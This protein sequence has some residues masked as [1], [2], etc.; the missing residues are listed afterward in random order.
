MHH[1]KCHFYNIYALF[2]LSRVIKVTSII[3]N[4]ETTIKTKEFTSSNGVE[5]V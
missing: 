1:V 4:G 5:A 2:F 3:G